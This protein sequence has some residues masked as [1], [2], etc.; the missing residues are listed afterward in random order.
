MI[1]HHQWKTALAPIMI[2]GLL[3]LTI[4]A[5]V[6][7]NA[8]QYPFEWMVKNYNR[9]IVDSVAARYGVSPWFYNLV[10]IFFFWSVALLAFWLLARS[11]QRRQT[12]FLV[13]GLTTIVVHSFI[14]HKEYR[15]ILL[16]TA[17]L[18]MWAV[19]GGGAVVRQ[20]TSR[21]PAV[22][23][24]SMAAGVMILWALLSAWRL[25]VYQSVDYASSPIVARAM[26]MARQ[27]PQL[28]GFAVLGFFFG[29]IGAHSRLHRPVQLIV[30]EKH[31][32]SVDPQRFNW[33]V[34]KREFA[35]VLPR[36]FTKVSCSPADDV[37]IYRRAGV[38]DPSPSPFELNHWLKKEGA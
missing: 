34:A 31:P 17:A 4:S 32:E 27:D 2:G 22:S 8:G 15:F 19:P 25:S 3:A 13:V 11:N 5:L 28:C 21:F 30:N 10:G 6:D 1:M 33:A 16:G 12:V 14:A 24:R 29:D 37:C 35:P 26:D 7:W 38:C 23:R 20:L 18:M 36:D 9:N